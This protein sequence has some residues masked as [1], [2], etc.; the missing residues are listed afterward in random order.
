MRAVKQWR[1]LGCGARKWLRPS[2]SRE[3]IAK[4]SPALRAAT[5]RDQSGPQ[6]S[7]HSSRQDRLARGRPLACMA[8]ALG[9]LRLGYSFLIGIRTIGIYWSGIFWDSGGS[10]KSISRILTNVG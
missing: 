5:S 9:A 4:D 7:R 3:S 8:A 6:L 10:C 1:W 2:L